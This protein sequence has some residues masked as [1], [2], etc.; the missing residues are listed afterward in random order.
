MLVKPGNRMKSL[1]EWS[2]ETISILTRKSSVLDN[3]SQIDLD[4]KT[5]ATLDPC[6]PNVF[7]PSAHIAIMSDTIGF[8]FN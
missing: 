6:L 5:S 2:L 8:I 4:N 1:Y 7:L 3:L